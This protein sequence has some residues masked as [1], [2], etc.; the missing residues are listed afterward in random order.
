MKSCAHK[1]LVMWSLLS[2]AFVAFSGLSAHAAEPK[3]LAGP[4]IPQSTLRTEEVAIVTA[5]GDK[6]TFDVEIAR[7]PNELAYGL[8][9][10]TGMAK[11]HGMLFLFNDEIERSFWMKNTLISLDMIFIRSDG[12]ILRIHPSAIPNDLTPI[13]SQ[14]PAM[15]VL[16]LN[17]GRAADLG[18]KAG[19][20]V[21][22]KT[23]QKR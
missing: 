6:H 16:E 7:T 23:F 8:M 14:G 13:F 17:G 5:K 10:R 12:T 11:D 20:R 9:N 2:L 22:Y 4:P 18:I 15:A 21:L 1:L 19:D 3:K